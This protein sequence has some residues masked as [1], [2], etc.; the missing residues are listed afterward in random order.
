ME[1]N[2]NNS[3]EQVIVEWL[4]LVDRPVATK[5]EDKKSTGSSDK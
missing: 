4:R 5:E 2:N 3:E 1:E